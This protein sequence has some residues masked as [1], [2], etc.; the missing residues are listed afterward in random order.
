MSKKLYIVRHQ[1]ATYTILA[2]YLAV[3]IVMLIFSNVSSMDKC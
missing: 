1:L 3:N 2:T